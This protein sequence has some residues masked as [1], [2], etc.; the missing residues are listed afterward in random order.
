MERVFRAASFS[1]LKHHS[2]GNEKNRHGLDDLIGNFRVGRSQVRDLL[3]RDEQI[4][5]DKGLIEAAVHQMAVVFLVDRVDLPIKRAVTIK[6]EATRVSKGAQRAFLMVHS[7][8]WKG[9]S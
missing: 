2:Y 8:H 9:T 7:S 4:G 1:W 5:I 3:M 6:D